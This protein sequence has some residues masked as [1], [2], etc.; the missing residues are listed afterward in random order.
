METT[1]S[2]DR[3]GGSIRCTA[4]GAAMPAAAFN[5]CLLQNIRR[6]FKRYS[7]YESTFH[8]GLV[9][10][11]R[12][13]EADVALRLLREGIAHVAGLLGG[14]EDG[15]YRLLSRRSG[16]GEARIRRVARGDSHFTPHMRFRVF[17]AIEAIETD[18]AAQPL[19]TRG[20]G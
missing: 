8:P 4:L 14:D 3:P 7:H 11:S 10:P 13:A 15:A 9:A 6:K 19:S 20:G 5:L 1:L 16:S 12:P 2:Q 18:H 17:C